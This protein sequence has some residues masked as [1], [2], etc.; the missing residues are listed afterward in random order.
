[1]SIAV[2]SPVV[3][4]HPD[5]NI[6]IAKRA[7][8]KGG[9]LQVDALGASI[10]AADRIDIGH[11]VAIRPIAKGAAVRKFGQLIGYAT[12]AIQPGDWVHSHNLS[13]GALSLQYEFA[14]AVPPE[15]RRINGRTFLGYRRRDG[16]VA[17]RNYI[18]V[19]ST[20]NCS[21]TT[22]KYVA[23]RLDKSL[24][25]DFPNIDGVIPLVH[26]AGC[27][28]QYGGEDHAQLARTLAGFARH[29]NIA[30]YIVL[31]LGCET[32]QASF[33]VNEHQLTQL[34]FP[35]MERKPLPLVMN[36]QDEG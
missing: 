33:L 26:K 1:M 5:D 28:M 30:A 11:K 8:A 19:I 25:A 24:L 17:T 12:E 14:T 29:P 10:V 4:L 18:G 27:A 15:P 2:D 3:F 6:A 16:R 35:G 22:S 20:V 7:V 36:I 13:A 34:E 9:E 32:G 23:A 31:G 21:A